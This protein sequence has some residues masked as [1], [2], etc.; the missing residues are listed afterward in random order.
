MSG[1]AWRAWVIGLVAVA[2]LAAMGCRARVVVRADPRVERYARNLVRVAA[3]DT[4]CHPSQLAPVQ[5]AAEPA[6]FTVTG[7]QTPVEY[8]LQ[9]G[10]R[11]CN[12]RRVATLN[13]SAAP[14]LQCAPHMI[15]VQPTQT[16]NVRFAAG[17]GRIAPFTVACNGAACGWSPSGPVQ[18][19]GGPVAAAPPQQPPPATAVVVP[20]PQP[21]AAPPTALQ[22]QVQSQREAI[23]S[24]I[25]SGSLT[26]RLRWTS[27]GQVVVQL[28]ADLVGTAAEGCI[29]AVLGGMRVAAQ[30]AGEIVVPVQ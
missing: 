14:V 29:Q 8:W 4:G 7:C 26:L 10:R 27:D 1:R 9:C 28:P 23:L 2:S 5:V 6:V 11:N 19:G 16:P 30:A 20:G 25:D 15:Q 22:S 13:E 21:Q 3:R 17:C 18:A 24:C 12:W